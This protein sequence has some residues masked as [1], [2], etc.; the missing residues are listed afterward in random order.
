MT[1]TTT[2]TR[3]GVTAARTTIVAQT[4]DTTH[5]HLVHVRQNKNH[6][7]DNVQGQDHGIAARDHQGIVDGETRHVHSR[8]VMLQLIHVI[9]HRRQIQVDK[10]RP[11]EDLA[12]VEVEVVIVARMVGIVMIVI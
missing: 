1:T 6:L 4:N 11:D 9:D 12:E 5:I 2:T 10:E 8:L 3:V 7:D